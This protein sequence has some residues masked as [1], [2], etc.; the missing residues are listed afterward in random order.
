MFSRIGIFIRDDTEK[1]FKYTF[2]RV[3]DS[4]EIFCF[5]IN[6]SCNNFGKGQRYSHAFIDTNLPNRT[7][8]DIIIPSV[9]LEPRY[10][11]II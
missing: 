11:D 8:Q 7:I 5:H 9:S 2:F 10:I 4:I 3:S 6:S 1:T